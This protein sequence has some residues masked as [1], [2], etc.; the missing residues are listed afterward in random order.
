MA[1][2]V[3]GSGIAAVTAVQAL[4]ANGYTGPVKMV[5]N[6]APP[7]YYRPLLP[8]LIDGSKTVE[9]IQLTTD[10][11][12]AFGITLVKETVRAVN[13]ADRTV[14]LSSGEAL[15]YEKLLIASGSRPVTPPVKGL[16]GEGVFTLR[17]AADALAIREY[18][19]R[20]GATAA[21]VV[22]GGLIGVKAAEALRRRG[23]KV[24]VIELLPTILSPL[25]DAAG[26]AIL[27]TRLRAAG[28]DVL[29]NQRLEAVL[30]ANGSV[31]GL[32]LPDGELSAGVI[33]V[34]TGVRP[35]TSFLAGSGI[36]C[37]KGILVDEHLRTSVPDIWAAGDVIEYQ[38]LFTGLPI[39][40][41]LWV[42]AVCTGKI[43]G[44]NMAGGR[45][46]CPGFLPALNAIE[47][48]GL[49]VIAAG[50]PGVA[51]DDY[52]VYAAREGE[53]YRRVV[54]QEERLIG[55]LLI[56]EV[57]RAGV[58]VSLIGSQ[59]SLPGLAAALATDSLSYA[60]VAY[61]SKLVSR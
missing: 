25:V 57:A 55:V 18:L 52:Q 31:A 28:I 51:G 38:D 23:L 59:K 6:D 13:P 3:I 26:A 16:E 56:G 61:L 8:F 60:R 27:T 30:R 36:A 7:F 48:A 9:E 29:V 19:D 2:V 47:V 44:T 33:V 12:A 4:R 39:T 22:G 49:P 14:T 20:S 17:T 11:V 35:N 1:V 34:A 10:P 21:A 37:G 53:N 45:L 40:S 42:N 5:T 15:A 58:Y 32:R 41:G 24:T 43:A 46:R 50:L 54:L